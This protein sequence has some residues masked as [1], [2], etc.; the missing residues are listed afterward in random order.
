M[1]RVEPF[2]DEAANH[3]H[4]VATSVLA[5]VNRDSKRRPEPYKA[6]DFMLAQVAPKVDAELLADPEAQSRLI[7][8]RLFKVQG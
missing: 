6:A 2:G 3:R 1:F 4:G 8:R 5:N 7:K